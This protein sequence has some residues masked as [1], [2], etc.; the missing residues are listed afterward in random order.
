MTRRESLTAAIDSL[1]KILGPRP[2]QPTA[3]SDETNW[4]AFVNRAGALCQLAEISPTNESKSLFDEA[5]SSLEYAVSVLA[6]KGKEDLLRYTQANLG[7]AY[8][9]LGIS[10]ENAES[11]RKAVQTHRAALALDLRERNAD[12]WA[13]SQNNRGNSLSA[14]AQRLKGGESGELLLDAMGCYESA[15]SVWSRRRYPKE[16]R[17][18]QSNIA[19]RKL[20]LAERLT[21]RG[22]RALVDEAVTINAE[23]LKYTDRSGQPSEWARVNNNLGAALRIYS[24]LQSAPQAVSCLKRAEEAHRN[25][26]SVSQDIQGPVRWAEAQMNLGNVLVQLGEQVP[27]EFESYMDRAAEAYHFAREA[28]TLSDSRERWGSTLI[29][30]ANG[31]G[32]RGRRTSGDNGVR[33]LREA[34]TIYGQ[35]LEVLDQSHFPRQWAKAQSSFASALGDLGVRTNDPRAFGRAVAASRSALQVFTREDDPLEWGHAQ[36]N[37]GNALTAVAKGL[38]PSGAPSVFLQALD[39]FDGALQVFTRSDFRRDW[40]TITYNKGA[41]LASMAEQDTHSTGVE[42]FRDAIELFREVATVW[43]KDMPMQWADNQMNLAIADIVLASRL[44]G[45]ER[46]NCLEEASACLAGAS[47]VFSGE[48]WVLQQGKISRLRTR[49]GEL[50]AQS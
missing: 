8:Q 35:T 39:A 37:L 5:I 46:L 44:T 15:A 34:A 29:N 23:L 45:K 20:D 50:K 26:I 7:F 36:T 22:Q 3:A 24:N 25:A 21:G 12:L 6:S 16:W 42:L 31:L 49:L 19:N 14:L 18:V 13:N 40:A 32:E 28:G 9:Q 47:A 38:D 11:L 33:L 41:L 30:T 27:Q 1:E 48:P 4:A 43:T 17:M 10:S 2:W